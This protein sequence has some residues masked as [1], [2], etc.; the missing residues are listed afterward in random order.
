MT[1]LR[2]K[3]SAGDPGAKEVLKR[4]RQLQNGDQKLK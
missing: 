4:L 2:A 3:A 1:E